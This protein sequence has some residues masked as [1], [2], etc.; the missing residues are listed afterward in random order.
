M[1]KGKGW[2]IPRT[3]NRTGKG[4]EKMKLEITVNKIFS[5]RAE[6][7]VQH[8]R[9]LAALPAPPGSVPNTHMAAHNHL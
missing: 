1:A 2:G 5:V 3:Q 6:E 9:A 7:V 8:L 4:R